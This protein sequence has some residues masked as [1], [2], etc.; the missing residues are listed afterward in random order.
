MN[1][2]GYLYRGKL[3]VVDCGVMFPDPAKLGVEAIYPD[4][5]P[6]FEQMGGVHA[7]VI[8]HGHE[9]H[10]GAL[11]YVLERWPAPVYATPWTASLIEAK[12]ERRKLSG[13]PKINRIQPGGSLDLAVVNIDWIPVNH[14]IPMASALLMRFGDKTVFHTG[15]FRIDT[16]TQY[17]PPVDLQR[18]KQLG[19][20]GIDLLVCDSTNAHRPGMGP[21]ELSIVD[22]LAQVFTDATGAVVITTFASNYWRIKTIAN[23]CHRFQKKLLILGGG[24]DQAIRIAEETGFEP[25]PDGIRISDDQLANGHVPRD[26]VVVLATGSQGEW[27]SALS[28]ISAGEH[29]AFK[30]SPGDTVVFSSRIIPGNEKSVLWLTNNF[31]RAGAKVITSRDHPGIHVSGHAYAGEIRTLIDALQPRHFIPMHGTYSHLDAN[32]SLFEGQD[33]F[34]MEDG[35]VIELS[36]TGCRKSDS[37]TMDTLFVDSGS[38]ASL[39]RETLRER[40]RV[41]E[42]G[43]AFVSGVFDT[44]DNRWLRT[45]EIILQ[46]I[47]FRPEPGQ[48]GPVNRDLW[49]EEA[50]MY[51]AEAVERF[52]KTQ[53]GADDDDL[54]EEA[55]LTLRRLLFGSLGR[56]PQVF[57]K[58]HG[59]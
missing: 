12:F 37:V 45:P 49:V 44:S 25:L 28:R 35:D 4:I 33:P 58:V 9:D 47:N 32:L 26:R 22:P 3:V 11:P 5:S 2:T 14:S 52:A 36:T 17:E 40:L 16:E 46:G 43:C 42:G 39:S 13:M 20:A 19:D 59:F 21:S 10:I 23:L 34:L 55:R 15:D 56:K 18:L 24:I 8:T 54:S 29:R 53:P 31:Q 50:S 30:I 1:M 57:A 7:Y 48:Q 6:I 51:V 41:G 38:Y 27:R